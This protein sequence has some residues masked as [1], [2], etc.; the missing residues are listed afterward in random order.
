MKNSDSENSGG[1]YNESKCWK[2]RRVS[3]LWIKQFEPVIGWDAD[4]FD[5]L[6][7]DGLT[8]D[9]YF[10]KECPQFSKTEI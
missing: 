1:Y 3:C 10:V 2:C 6:M 9:S 4:R 8:V 5:Y 7:D